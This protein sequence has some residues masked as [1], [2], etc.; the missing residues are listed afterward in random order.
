MK[1]EFKKWIGE[2]LRH[3]REEKIMLQSELA[4]KLQIKPG[5]YA[6]YE[7]GRATPKIF[8]LKEIC[9][10]FSITM[11]EFLEGSPAELTEAT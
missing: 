9:K 10:L 6:S 4:D 5:T 3:F 8:T 7:E 11:D 2:R 1:N